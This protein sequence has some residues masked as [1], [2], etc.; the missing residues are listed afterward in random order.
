MSTNDDRL[1]QDLA[2][3]RKI[4]TC[5]DTSLQT[6][7]ELFGMKPFPVGSHRHNLQ[8]PLSHACTCM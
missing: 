4:S 3:N 8:N 5:I 6:C 1:Y 2:T 7:T